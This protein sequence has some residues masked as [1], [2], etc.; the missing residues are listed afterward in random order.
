MMDIQELHLSVIARI[1]LTQE[2]PR[3]RLQI[4]RRNRDVTRQ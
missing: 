4:L 3:V 2:E 1:Q